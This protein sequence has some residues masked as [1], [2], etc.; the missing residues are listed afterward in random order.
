M[1]FKSQYLE[2]LT[3]STQRINLVLVPKLENMVLI[4]EIVLISSIQAE[5]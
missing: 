1:P 5:I 4:N 2:F 3:S